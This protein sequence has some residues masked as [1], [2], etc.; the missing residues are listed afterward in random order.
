MGHFTSKCGH[1]IYYSG[2]EK[3]GQSG[4]AFIANKFISNHV[5]GYNPVNDRIITIRL[6]R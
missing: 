5:L 6:I 2:K 1:T 3:G 4:V